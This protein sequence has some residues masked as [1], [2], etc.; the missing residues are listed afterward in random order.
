[1]N[2]IEE[3]RSQ[4]NLVRVIHKRIMNSQLMTKSEILKTAQDL[5]G[6]EPRGGQTTIEITTP[7][8]INLVGVANCSK[9]DGFCRKTGVRFALERA[10]AQHYVVRK[11]GKVLKTFELELAAKNWV[12]YQVTYNGAN[13]EE[14]EIKYEYANSR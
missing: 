3:L 1:M 11:H 9:D 5:S 8:G 6:V 10:L 7:E 13:R 4:K 14:Y 2:K 12:D